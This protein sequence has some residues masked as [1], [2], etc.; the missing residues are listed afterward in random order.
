MGTSGG[1]GGGGR[2]AMRLRRMLSALALVCWMAPQPLQR[3]WCAVG[4]AATTAAAAVPDD[5][6]SPA[7]QYPFHRNNHAVILSSSRYWFNYR[8]ATN[9]LGIYQLLK[10]EHGFEDGNIVLMVADE[11]CVNPRNAIKNAMYNT[12]TDSLSAAV[13]GGPRWPSQYTADT[14]IDYRGEDVTVENWIRVLT[15]Q[16]HRPGGLPVLHTDANSNI[17][18]YL[19][20]HGGDQFF[21]FQDY[22][23][24]T[25][26]QLNG[27]LWQMHAARRYHEILLVAD[28]CQAHTLADAITAPNVTVIGT[29]L[30]GE[31]S[32]AHHGDSTIGLSVIEK[33]THY[34][35]QTLR[36]GGAER[37]MDDD[38]TTV[39]R[40]MVEVFWN[41]TFNRLGATVG[42]N[43][44]NAVRKMS[45][46][47]LRDFMVSVQS[48]Q[49]WT[50]RAQPLWAGPSSEEQNVPI[51]LVSNTEMFSLVLEMMLPKRGRRRRQQ[52]HRRQSDA[53][54]CLRSDS[55]STAD[56]RC[57]A[58]A[59]EIASS[60]LPILPY[61]LSTMGA[62]RPD[63]GSSFSTDT[64]R[65]GPVLEPT[66]PL[67]VFLIVLLGA[68]VKIA[69]RRWGR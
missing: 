23:E 1:G 50:G 12:A 4:A 54:E 6:S 9:A 63:N 47:P 69:T 15:G 17:L 33:Y 7:Q 18:L 14:S 64:P 41:D 13:H 48:P 51:R 11:Y 19:T 5:S 20:G 35:L 53:G 8:H 43:D 10:R 62:T 32:Y 67:F 57:A 26:Q 37:R 61:S 40:A 31:S 22:E 55:G 30:K 36:A 45:D 25:S 68:S 66:S 2:I 21:K 27:V 28:T 44:D 46:V 49:F 65:G 60:A 39:F 16:Q 58:G 29:S 56:G 59:P 52:L 34:F 42:M 3:P 38:S 24:L